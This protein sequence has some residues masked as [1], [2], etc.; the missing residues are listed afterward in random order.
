MTRVGFKLVM[1]NPNIV[2]QESQTVIVFVEIPDECSMSE[3]CDIAKAKAIESVPEYTYCL[4]YMYLGIE[5]N[6]HIVE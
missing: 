2:N 3:A 5:E 4:D 1:A 6:I